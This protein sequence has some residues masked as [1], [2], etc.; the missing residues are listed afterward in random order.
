MKINLV[1]VK[2]VLHLLLL[3]R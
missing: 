1:K 2:K 3:W